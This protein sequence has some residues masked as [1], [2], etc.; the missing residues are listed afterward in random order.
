[1]SSCRL[2]ALRFL[3]AEAAVAVA[4]RCADLARVTAASLSLVST[5]KAS[6]RLVGRRN[7]SGTAFRIM[8]NLSP[9]TRLWRSSSMAMLRSIPS[10]LSMARRISAIS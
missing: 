4:A 8:A 7:L 2:E 6:E 10:T 1:M 5:P 9:M 3:P